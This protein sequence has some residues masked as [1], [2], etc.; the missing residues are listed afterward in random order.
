MMLTKDYV[1]GSCLTLSDSDRL[2]QSK[3]GPDR[4]RQSA[5]LAKGGPA[6]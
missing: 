6:G 3:M 5:T 4:Q 2:G 1:S